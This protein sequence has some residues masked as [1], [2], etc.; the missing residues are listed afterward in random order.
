MGLIWSLDLTS[1]KVAAPATSSPA[2][3]AIVRFEL[4]AGHAVVAT[5][6]LKQL[7]VAASV[8]TQE[9]RE[10]GLVAKL[11]RPETGGP[12][13]GILI[14]G[15]SE[16]GIGSAEAHA[17]LLASHGYAALAVAYFGME[18]LPPRL[19]GVP[20]DYLRKAIDWM[21]A[22]AGID[23]RR[24]G[25]LGWSKGGELA[26]LL[27]SRFPELKAVVAY[28]PSH[29]VWQGIGGA[30]AS[31][32]YR[33]E[34]LDFVPYKSMPSSRNTTGPL[35]YMPYY[36]ASLENAEAVTKAAIP[37]EKIQGP[38]MLIS[39]KDDQL[40]PS[41]IMAERVIAR[42]REYKHGHR[43]EHLSYEQA[44]H[45]IE[46]TYGPKTRSMSAGRTVLGGTPAGN[47][48]AQSDSWPKV[49]EFLN[50]SLK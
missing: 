37:V 43:S 35:S 19:V 17:A 46:P 44:G 48:R 14:L 34:P 41:S 31:W 24:L 50:D 39:G 21:T 25:V 8:K 49:L 5:S 23:R 3:S 32:S 4:E 42:L 10:Q 11:Y 7:S 16:G 18:D 40:W 12:H 28:V 27:A 9:V 36:L 47:A 38:I 2:S 29:V 22:Q 6:H 15:G 30:G 20:L 13:P 26:L 33:G 45:N 1:E